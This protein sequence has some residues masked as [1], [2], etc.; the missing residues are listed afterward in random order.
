MTEDEISDEVLE[1]LRRG[2]LPCGKCDACIDGLNCQT[3]A[4]T[5]LRKQQLL[6][7]LDHVQA[8]RDRFGDAIRNHRDQRGDDR[9]YLDDAELY[10]VLGEGPAVTVLPPREAF[11]ANCA[12]FHASRQDPSEKYETEEDRH[13]ALKTLL[14]EWQLALHAVL[15][16]FHHDANPPSSLSPK[17]VRAA[18]EVLVEERDRLHELLLDTE[19]WGPLGTCPWCKQAKHSTDCPAFEASGF[20]RFGAAPST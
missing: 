2:S 7:R 16:G 20:I 13:R 12:R 6:A 8:E 18:Y 1:W 11:L 19:K 17:D 10:A 15:P 9:C 3:G 5:T 14:I 4:L